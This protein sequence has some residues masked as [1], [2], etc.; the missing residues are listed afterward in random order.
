[1]KWILTFIVAFALP[2]IVFAQPAFEPITEINLCIF[3]NGFKT[4]CFKAV[5]GD[6]EVVVFLDGNKEPFL[7]VKVENDTLTETLWR[8]GEVRL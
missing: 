7:I 8:R 1:M 4:L 3:A 5:M 6:N 2:N